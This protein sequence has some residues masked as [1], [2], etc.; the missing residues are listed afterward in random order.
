MWRDRGLHPL[1]LAVD[2]LAAQR[3]VPA[4]LELAEVRPACTWICDSHFTLATPY[5]PGNE[6]P[7]RR[8]LM[9]GQR[10]AVERLGQERLGRQRLLARAGC[11]RTAAR[12]CTSA[13]ATR[14]S[15]SPWSAPKNTN[16]RA[17]ALDAGA[18]RAP[19]SAA[20]R[21]TCRCS[22]APAAAARLPEH[23]KP[24]TNSVLPHLLQI[25]ERQRLRL[26][27]PGR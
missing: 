4:R 6:Q 20:R 5:Q 26:V 15:S 12:R 1:H 13:S 8:A 9:L 14:P 23:S 25:V 19:S 2:H 24:A 10:L 17:S 21:S 27:R 16:S 22:R 3:A 18:H 7:Q 11:G